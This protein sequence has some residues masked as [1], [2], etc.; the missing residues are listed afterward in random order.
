MI[1][2]LKKIIDFAFSLANMEEVID[3]VFSKPDEITYY[4]NDE[5][6]FNLEK[7]ILKEKGYII[8]NIKPSKKFELLLYEIKFIFKLKN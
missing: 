7:E 2:T 1:I 8:N 5:E 3:G 4:L 6:L